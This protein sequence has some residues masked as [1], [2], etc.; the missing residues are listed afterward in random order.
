MIDWKNIS[1]CPLCGKKLTCCNLAGDYRCTDCYDNNPEYKE[2]W[3]A[4]ATNVNE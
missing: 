2:A 3:D 1:V 4:R